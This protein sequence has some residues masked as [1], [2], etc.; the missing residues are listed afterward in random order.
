VLAWC[1]IGDEQNVERIADILSAKRLGAVA[2]EL[3][4]IAVRDRLPT[5]AQLKTISKPALFKH[6][7]A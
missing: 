7:F 1:Y 5:P 2:M 6:L 3:R 4:E